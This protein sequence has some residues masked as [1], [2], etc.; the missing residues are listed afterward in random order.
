M[1]QPNNL[2]KGISEPEIVDDF[3]KKL[4]HPLKPIVEYLRTVI[5]SADKSIGE[6]IYWNA[7]TFYYTGKMKPFE[8]K[9]Y[10]RYIVGFNFYKQDNLR[11]IFLRG[12]DAADPKGL[13]TGNFKDKRKLASFQNIEQVKKAEA[14]LVKIIKD[15][16]TKIDQ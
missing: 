12:A 2:M 7:P 4:D 15:L 10:K 9:E 3:L 5:V 14:D 6:G 13:L 11:L 8:P 16:I 1:K